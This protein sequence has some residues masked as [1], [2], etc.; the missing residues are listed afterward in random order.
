MIDRFE[1]AD[2][3]VVKRAC[4]AL[5]RRSE[6]RCVIHRPECEP[7]HREQ[8]WRGRVL[9][10]ERLGNGFIVEVHREDV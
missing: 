3:E 2:Q 9:K 7:A 10:V 5:R 1:T 4:L 6:F 8:H